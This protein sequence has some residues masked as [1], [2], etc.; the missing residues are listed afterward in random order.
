MS[1]AIEEALR[2]VRSAVNQ[3][4][5]K[6]TSWFGEVPA[7]IQSR[8]NEV[9]MLVSTAEQKAFEH[10]WNEIVKALG[11]SQEVLRDIKSR[12]DRYV[13]LVGE[14]LV[15]AIKTAVDDITGYVGSATT[16]A[17]QYAEL[18]GATTEDYI[19]RGSGRI[20]SI[21]HYYETSGKTETQTANDN[22]DQI[23][24]DQEKLSGDALNDLINALKNIFGVNVA[25]IE[26]LL[27]SVTGSLESSIRALSQQIAGAMDIPRNLLDQV[28]KGAES[29]ATVLAEGV[30]PSIDAIT[31]ALVSLQD[32]LD[33][34]LE[35]YFKI[36]PEKVIEFY[37]QLER[38]M[39]ERK[40]GVIRG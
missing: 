27:K 2:S 10:A 33:D 36:D 38:A 12:A 13:N 8:V 18:A 6:L 15:G 25:G 32:F 1:E 17:K 34:A 14:G 28:R 11:I 22:M 30:I 16:R 21:K 20:E 29:M 3:F 4:M 24:K 5:I 37:D 40:V 26:D 31:L 35:E 7:E 23:K 19:R 39:L 9:V